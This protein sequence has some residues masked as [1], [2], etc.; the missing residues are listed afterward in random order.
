MELEKELVGLG[1]GDE[2]SLELWQ[3]KMREMRG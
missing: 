2:M 3:E 1:I